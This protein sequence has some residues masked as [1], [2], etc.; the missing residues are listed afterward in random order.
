MILDIFKLIQQ[1]CKSGQNLNFCDSKNFEIKKLLWVRS[2][3][4]RQDKCEEWVQFQLTKSIFA[5]KVNLNYPLWGL[6]C[7]MHPFSIPKS[8][9]ELRPNILGPEKFFR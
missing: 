5:L 1:L 3:A 6:Y 4:M 7:K 2:N 9:I 8:K